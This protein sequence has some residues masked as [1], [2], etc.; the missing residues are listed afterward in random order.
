MP[1][2]KI[3]GGEK[4]SFKNSCTLLHLKKVGTKQY[5]YSMLMTGRLTLLGQET[6]QFVQ[7][8]LLQCKCGAVSTDVC[9]L[10]G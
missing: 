4:L 6:S 10:E 8:F 1:Q 9:N 2:R 7:A 5:I 3:G